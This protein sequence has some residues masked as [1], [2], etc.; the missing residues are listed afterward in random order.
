MSAGLNVMAWREVLER[1]FAGFVRQCDVSPDWLVNPGTR[2]RLK[3]DLLYPEIGIAIRFVGLQGNRRGAISDWEVAEQ[4]QREDVREELCRQQGIILVAIP[5]ISD[6]PGDVLRA[7]SDA[8][9]RA[10]RSLAKGSTRLS[11]KRR[12]MPL[13]AEARARC[14]QMISR[15][16][17]PDDLAFFA[18]LGR[19]REAA[20]VSSLEPTPPPR[21]RSS[22]PAYRPG[23]QVTHPTFGIGTIRALTPDGDDL[24]VTVDFVS[25]GERTLLASLVADKL[26]PA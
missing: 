8:I 3:L 4:E 14:E 24:R 16:R 18:E 21:P 25:A 9:G 26:K 22:L 15:I 13:L 12:L 7:L 10:T 5:V 6:R 19:D 2:R 23:M 1:I 20:L 17:R 11:E